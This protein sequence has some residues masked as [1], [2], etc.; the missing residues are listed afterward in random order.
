[1]YTQAARKHGKTM[2]THLMKR[3]RNAF[4]KAIVVGRM[5][6]FLLHMWKNNAVQ[7]SR[8]KMAGIPC[9]EKKHKMSLTLQLLWFVDSV[10]N[11]STRDLS[12]GSYRLPHEGRVLYFPR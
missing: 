10:R 2:P 12:H 7:Q 4:V 6:C 3:G 8:L 5:K 1:V 9:T 11:T